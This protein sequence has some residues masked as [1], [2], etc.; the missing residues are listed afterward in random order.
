MCDKEGTK[1]DSGKNRLDLI[2]PA[3]T[4]GIGLVLTFGA[5][6]YSA[7][8]WAKGI[9]FSKIIGALKRHLLAVEKGED[10]D[11]ESG[12]LHADHIACNAAFLQTFQRHNRYKKFD[13]RFDYP[14]KPSLRCATE[15]MALQ[16]QDEKFEHLINNCRI[17]IAKS[18]C[19]SAEPDKTRAYMCH[20]IRGRKGMDATE[21]EMNAN[22]DKAIEAGERLRW[23]HPELDVYVPGDHDEFVMIGYKNGTLSEKQ[24]LDI[25]CGIVKRC[26]AIV[27]YTE[28]GYL[29]RGMATEIKY[30]KKHKK[31]VW[32]Y[33]GTDLHQG[34]N[35]FVYMYPK[36]WDKVC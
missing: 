29:S 33:D 16:E 2:P 31:V 28:D 11:P 27:M 8:N 24:I 13:D 15:V 35:D 20:S 19:K 14:A 32:W 17:A 10:V 26:D 3:S 36:E 30:A 1:L 6:K 9:K 12:L 22:N 4:E 25:D 23:E 7:Y 34:L 21:D 5:E 18:L